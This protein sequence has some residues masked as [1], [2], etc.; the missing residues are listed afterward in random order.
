ME[1]FKIDKIWNSLVVKLC[2][3]CAFSCSLLPSLAQY[4]VPNEQS[5]VLTKMKSD[6]NLNKFDDFNVKAVRYDALFD[7]V[8]KSSG[9]RLLAESSVS[10]RRISYFGKH[11]PYRDFMMEIATISGLEWRV[12][13]KRYALPIKGEIYELFQ[14]EE[15]RKRE[16]RLARDSKIR[17]DSEFATKTNDIRNALKSAPTGALSDFIKNFSDEDLNSL[18][19]A[20]LAPA[21]LISANNQSVFHDRFLL[22]QPFSDL[23]QAAKD[24]LVT[25]LGKNYSNIGGVA[26][27]PP[28]ANA[29]SIP[30]S[31]IGLIAIEGSVHLGVFALDGDD[32]WISPNDSV[33]IPGGSTQEIDDLDPK[34]RS[35]FDS[36]NLV[37]L[38][39]MPNEIRKKR[40]KFSSVLDRRYL[41]NF[42][43]SIHKQTN[44][45]LVCDDYLRTRQTVFGGIFSDK[46][47][48]SLEEALI[49]LARTYS[50]QIKYSNGC[51]FLNTLT[52]G[53][54]LRTEP[55]GELEEMFAKAD[56][57]KRSLN[58]KEILELGKLSKMQFNKFQTLQPGWSVKQFNAVQEIQR[59]FSAI[60]FFSLLT[61]EEVA[62]ACTDAGL[63]I[64]KLSPEMKKEYRRASSIGFRRPNPSLKKKFDP[65]RF[66]CTF[67]GAKEAPAGL[68]MYF[69]RDKK[70]PIVHTLHVE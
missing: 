48:Y 20:S 13:P 25:I 10:H 11:V 62:E 14:P 53:L 57:E 12:A 70:E 35:M 8:Y 5:E 30:S 29:A 45:T 21:G 38:R 66:Y 39:S 51:L 58:L 32:V 27:Q 15:S 4:P 64:K 36:A 17:E 22:P 61:P 54:D 56:F 68:A 47:E 18:A 6:L 28:V 19:E 33:N 7:S 65:N 23:P 41:A 43:E 42:L 49:Q 59:Q 67:R 40:L 16:E 69:M 55:P 31:Q 24:G 50:H 2:F 63:P 37:N 34:I 3:A 26:F 52:P 46:L 60:H 44:L 1:S 9:V